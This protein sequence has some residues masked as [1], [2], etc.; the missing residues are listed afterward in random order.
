MKT[1]D[2]TVINAIMNPTEQIWYR[3]VITVI[4]VTTDIA[5]TKNNMGITIIKDTTN[6]KVSNA[7]KDI[8]VVI[9]KTNA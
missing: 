3:P 7:I 8:A 6:M 2:I 5:V 1:T 9:N 4:K